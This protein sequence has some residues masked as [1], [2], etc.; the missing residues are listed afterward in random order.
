MYAGQVEVIFQPATLARH[1]AEKI[2]TVALPA[3]LH[4]QSSSRK[5]LPRRPFSFPASWARNNPG[6][7]CGK[8]CG[9]SECIALGITRPLSRSLARDTGVCKREGWLHSVCSP[10]L[11]VWLARSGNRGSALLLQTKQV[12]GPSLPPRTFDSCAH[13]KQLG[14]KSPVPAVCPHRFCSATG[15]APSSY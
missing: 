6:S 10:P 14:V 12:E 2:R 3:L 5:A 1:Q 13:A 8:H 15:R 11:D 9:L 7:P 4:G